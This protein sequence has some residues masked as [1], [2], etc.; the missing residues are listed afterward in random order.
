[1]KAVVTVVGKDTVG[2]LAKVSGICAENQMNVVEVSQTILQDMF[3][4]IMLVEGNDENSDFSKFSKMLKEE[5]E[6]VGLVIHSMHADVFE[7]MHHI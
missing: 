5:G 7:T 6:K 2:I 4:M 3:C 1:M